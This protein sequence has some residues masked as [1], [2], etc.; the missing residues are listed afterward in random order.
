MLGRSD[1]AWPFYALVLHGIPRLVQVA[2]VDLTG[3][4]EP[5]AA[6]ELLRVQ[7]GT[8]LLVIP[9]VAG[10]ERLIAALVPEPIPASA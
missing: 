10:L 2:E 1:A 7:V 5:D 8:E 4:L 9:D 6:G 3:T